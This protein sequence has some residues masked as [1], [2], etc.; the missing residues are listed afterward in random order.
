MLHHI[1]IRPVIEAI[2]ESDDQKQKTS[3]GGQSDF[4]DSDGRHD[5]PPSK[6]NPSE[7]SVLTRFRD[8]R[9]RRGVGRE[10]IHSP[11]RMKMFKQLA[12][13]SISGSSS[14]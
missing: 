14:T 5:D 9:C 4:G 12:F 2:I 8:D 6:S 13:A 11:V 10:S 7:I 3:A 1:E